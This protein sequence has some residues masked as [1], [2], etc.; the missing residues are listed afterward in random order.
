MQQILGGCQEDYMRLARAFDKSVIASFPSHDVQT[1]DNRQ[2]PS[3]ANGHAQ[4]QLHYRMPMN[5]YSG[6]PHP[7]PLIWEEPTPLRTTE[8]SRP[9]S[10]RSSPALVGSIFRDEPPK[11]APGM[12]EMLGQSSYTRGPSEHVTRPSRYHNGPSVTGYVEQI[13]Y[14]Y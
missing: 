14:Y 2:D 10:G 13:T 3:A 1:K 5:S 12:V 7:P 11:T 6:Q 4:S 8:Q 9:E